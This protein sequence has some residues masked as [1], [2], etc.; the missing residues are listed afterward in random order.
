MSLDS[1]S[2]PSDLP[3][4]FMTASG[5]TPAISCMSS[6]VISVGGFVEDERREADC[7][8]VIARRRSPLDTEIKVLITGSGMGTCSASAICFMRE[9]VEDV[10]SGLKRN[11]EQREA[12]GSIIRVT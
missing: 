6:D 7:R 3:K 2:T 1:D 11:F 9:E 5:T 10:S 12:R 4:E 8:Y